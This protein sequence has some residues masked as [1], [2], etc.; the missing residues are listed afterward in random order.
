MCAKEGNHGMFLKII[1]HFKNKMES[2]RG[3]TSSES[4]G[5][6]REKKCV[7]S[8]VDISFNFF[9]ELISVRA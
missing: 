2:W 5:H 6:Y 8:C 9:K 3:G 7:M 1:F 4:P